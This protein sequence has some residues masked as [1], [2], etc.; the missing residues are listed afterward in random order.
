MTRLQ[1]A[2]AGPSTYRPDIFDPARIGMIL[3]RRKMIFAAVALLFAIVVLAAYS[4]L[5][6]AYTATAQV[7]INSAHNNIIAPQ[8]Q[9][10]T[11][12]QPTTFAVDTQVEVLKSR[13][14]LRR[15]V[16]RGRLD[17]NPALL[18]KDVTPGTPEAIEVATD[19]IINNLKVNRSGVAFAIDVNYTAGNAQTAARVA[20]LVVEQYLDDQ[21][22]QKTGVTNAASDWLG[23]RLEHLRGQVL[24]AEAEVERY[25]SAN[26][27][28]ATARDE[29]GAQQEIQRLTAEVANARANLA[30]KQAA[31]NT[32][33]ARAK[34]AMAGQDVSEALSSNVI[35][36][37]R[38]QR[39]S[40]VATI[41]QLDA[42]YGSDYAPLSQARSQLIGIDREIRQEV[43]RI[44]SG[45]EGQAATAA[46]RVASLQ[47][48]LEQ[49]ETKL[50]SNS[51]AS[52]RLADLQRN[53]DAVRTLYETY[54]NRYRQ[55]SSQ[56]GLEESDARILARAVVPS[57]RSSPKLSFFLAIAVLGGIA[58]G[59]VAVALREILDQTLRTPDRILDELGLI[60]LASVPALDSL[61]GFDR[62]HRQSPSDF[63]IAQPRSLF[64]EALR[65]LRASLH[66][67]GAPKVLAIVS[68]LPSEGKSSVARALAQISAMAGEK[69]LLIEA[70]TRRAVGEH[71]APRPALGLVEVI[72]DTALL[73]ETLVSES[74]TGLVILPLSDRL[75]DP[76][77]IVGGPGMDR[78][79]EHL[80][81]RFD[82]IVID[83]AP[84]LAIADA[85]RV[86]AKADACCFVVRWGKTS[87]NAAETAVNLLK[88][89]GVNIVGAVLSHVD[90]RRQSAW[91]RNDPSAYFGAAKAYYR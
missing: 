20:N 69:V 3:R 53:A 27:L 63:L 14:S 4:Q 55:T 91:S 73:E 81:E 40:V 21:L 48:T 49:S 13:D 88:E 68:A 85:Q 87:S 71:D 60:T 36:Q 51:A 57:K 67:Q 77:D 90:L 76:P 12:D 16:Q 89:N 32:A 86:A 52:V 41:A 80:R 56:S 23:S 15:A 82:L 79:I 11:E 28:L 1:R 30:E 38:T 59:A 42:R 2:Y 29:M 47:G 75:P 58:A 46:G 33:R 78:V 37:L 25:R 18:T 24:T 64:A 74:A 45:L 19:T 17:R 62:A 9:V 26:G 22:Q 83:I 66:G 39:A 61:A 7:V 54:L 50:A 34:G 8:Q 84:A 43:R 5:K 6:P 65:M 72:G 70:D 10:V 31:A 35:T 44:I